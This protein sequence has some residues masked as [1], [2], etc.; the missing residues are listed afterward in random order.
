MEESR[1]FT[2]YLRQPIRGL[3]PVGIINGKLDEESIFMKVACRFSNSHFMDKKRVN[4][5]DKIP[6]ATINNI[7]QYQNLKIGEA[8]L[9]FTKTFKFLSQKLIFPQKNEIF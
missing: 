2:E 9:I 5:L 8:M 3:Q 4:N 6:M 7:T 1:I